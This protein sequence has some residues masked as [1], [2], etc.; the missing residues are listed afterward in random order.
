MALHP[1]R[2]YLAL[3]SED[4]ITVHALISSILECFHAGIMRTRLVGKKISSVILLHLATSRARIMMGTYCEGER[5][6]RAISREMTLF[7]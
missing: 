4:K 7:F 5:E 1:Q 3:W 2:N 6:K